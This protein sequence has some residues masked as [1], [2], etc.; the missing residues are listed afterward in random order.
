MMMPGLQSGYGQSA[1]PAMAGGLTPE[2]PKTSQ[3]SNNV[4]MIMEMPNC[5]LRDALA[6][7]DK[8]LDPTL[9]GKLEQDDF[10]VVI[11][12]FTKIWPN[13]PFL[14]ANARSVST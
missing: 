6:V 9:T 12:A 13:M 8:R 7:I 3:I 14:L 10:A 11:W 2:T 5:R 1:S 4:G